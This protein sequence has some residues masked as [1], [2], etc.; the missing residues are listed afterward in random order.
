MLRLRHETP[1]GA[2]EA[3]FYGAERPGFGVNSAETY[4]EI[5]QSLES[6]SALRYLEQVHGDKIHVVSKSEPGIERLG[7]GDA[8]ITCEVGTAL[9]IRTADC[10]PILVFCRK[11]GLIAAVHAGWRGLAARIVTQTIDRLCAH[12]GT[13]ASYLHFLVGPFIAHDS[14]EVGGEVAS[15]FEADTSS[16]R[17]NGKFSLDLGHA[18]AA[19]LRASSIATNQIEWQAIDTFAAR[20]WYS[21]RRGDSFRNFSLVVRRG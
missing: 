18:L 19:E 13:K 6:V 17:S 15:R 14:Y 21:A 2:I 11:T 1:A 16:L 7:E 9:V 4:T 12:F 10:I 3:R 20:E 5:L 8:M